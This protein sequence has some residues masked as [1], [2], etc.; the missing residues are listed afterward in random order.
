MK[1]FNHAEING[2]NTTDIQVPTTH[3]QQMLT[4]FFFLIL[5]SGISFMF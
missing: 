2:N 5:A 4:F 1:Y 3:T